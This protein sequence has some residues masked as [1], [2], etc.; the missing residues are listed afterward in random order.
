MSFRILYDFSRLSRTNCL[1]P[2]PLIE[3]GCRLHQ[4]IVLRA[5]SLQKHH[6]QHAPQHPNT[7][8]PPK[9]L[10]TI[11]LGKPGSNGST[12]S[13]YLICSSLRLIFNASMSACRCSIFRPPMIGK[14]CVVFCMT[15]AMATEGRKIGKS[16]ASISASPA[17]T[18][19]Q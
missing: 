9:T 2:R 14:T 5:V 4:P 12:P 7:Q 17:N 16:A 19:R 1:R 15:Y 3:L 8:K 13:R 11:V 6:N 10:T 18:H